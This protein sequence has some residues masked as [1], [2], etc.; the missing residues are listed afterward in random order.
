MKFIVL[1]Y[2][3]LMVCTGKIIGIWTVGLRYQWVKLLITH[4]ESNCTGGHCYIWPL[5]KMPVSHENA[6]D[7]L[8]KLNLIP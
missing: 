6:S 8:I 5:R 3:T 4:H 1:K 7:K 2:L